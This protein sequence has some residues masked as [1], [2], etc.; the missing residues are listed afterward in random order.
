MTGSAEKPFSDGIMKRTAPHPHPHP[1]WPGPSAS[2]TGEARS[3]GL[4]GGPW[5]PRRV[6][7]GNRCPAAAEPWSCARKQLRV[8]GI[9][10]A[11]RPCLLVATSGSNRPEPPLKQLLSIR[12][13]PPPP[14]P[15]SWTSFLFAFAVSCSLAPLHTADVD[16]H[17]GA[18]TLGSAHGCPPTPR[19]AASTDSSWGP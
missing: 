18:W 9:I 4:S 11:P 12:I 6:L 17:Q 16:G 1:H 10:H 7:P 19:A 13:P 2:I 3:P 8:T 14:P 5:G 15:S